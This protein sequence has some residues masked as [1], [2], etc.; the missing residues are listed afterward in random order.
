MSPVERII[1]I[2][3]IS[4]FVL[5][6]AC[7]EELTEAEKKAKEDAKFKY[8]YTINVTYYG[9]ETDKFYWMYMAKETPVLYDGCLYSDD[10]KTKAIACN[11]RSWTYKVAPRNPT[12]K[13]KVKPK[14]NLNNA[15]LTKSE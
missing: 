8:S 4:F 1:Q 14:E 2:S 6:F 11:V 13:S 10:M 12:V 5:L 15:G 3:A 7:N 9:G